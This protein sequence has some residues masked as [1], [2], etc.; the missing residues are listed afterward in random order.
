M[1]CHFVRGYASKEELEQLA[2]EHEV[3]LTYEYEEVE[4]GWCRKPK[5]LL[6]VLWERDY[7]DEQNASNYSLKGNACQLDED[8]Q[9]L[10][11]Y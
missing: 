9:V 4:E 3:E 7:I 11:E 5:G 6:Q 10:S 8:G 2:I 1:K